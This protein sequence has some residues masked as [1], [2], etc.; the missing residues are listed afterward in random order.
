MMQKKFAKLRVKDIS[1]VKRLIRRFL[2]VGF[3]RVFF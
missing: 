1:S 2:R 3:A